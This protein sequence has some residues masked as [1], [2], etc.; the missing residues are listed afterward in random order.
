MPELP[1][2]P[3]PSRT[4]T[5]EDL[6][7]KINTSYG[8]GIRSQ[9]TQRDTSRMSWAKAKN[10]GTSFG[11]WNGMPDTYQNNFGTNGGGPFTTAGLNYA[12]QT[13]KHDN[14]PYR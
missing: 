9:I 13:L 8:T 4:E 7:N 12:A 5:L 10:A 3:R 11:L 6:Y 14:T 1:S 2:T